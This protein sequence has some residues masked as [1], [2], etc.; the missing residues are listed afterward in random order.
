M[1]NFLASDVGIWCKMFWRKSRNIHPRDLTDGIFLNHVFCDIAK[2]DWNEIHQRL[3]SQNANTRFQNWKLLVKNLQEYYLDRLEHSIV[4]NPPSIFHIVYAPTSGAAVV[5]MEKAVLLLLLAAIKCEHREYFIRQIME[6]LNADVQRGIMQSITYFTEGRDG[7]LSLAGIHDLNPE[8]ELTLARAISNR[9][10]LYFRLAEEVILRICDRHPDWTPTKGRYSDSEGPNSSPKEKNA[11]KRSHSLASLLDLLGG[12]FKG[13]CPSSV[14]GGTDPG[15]GAHIRHHSGSTLATRSEDKQNDGKEAVAVT[16][17]AI[18][19]DEAQNLVD[20]MEGSSLDRFLAAVHMFEIGK[21]QKQIIDEIIELRSKSRKQGIQISEQTDELA[22]LHEQL[23]ES[24]RELSQLRDERARLADAAVC[25]RHWQDEAD[26]GQQAIAQL[27]QL[28]KEFEKLKQRLDAAQYYKIRCQELGEEI[29]VLTEECESLKLR[30]SK[31][32]EESSKLRLLEEKILE[33]SKR[34]LDLE[35]QHDK[36]LEEIQWMRNELT[37]LQLKTISSVRLQ[38]LSPQS[39]E[40]N[41]EIS[42]IND[43]LNLLLPD[44]STEAGIF[45]VDLPTPPPPPPAIEGGMQITQEIQIDFESYERRLNAVEKQL[46]QALRLSDQFQVRT[47]V[48]CVEETNAGF[49]NQEVSCEGNG[50]LTETLETFIC[51]LE[52]L[53]ADIETTCEVSRR[54][55][56]K[57]ESTQTPRVMQTSVQSTQTD[58]WPKQTT[59]ARDA[60]STANITRI[61]MFCTYAPLDS[62][63]E[64]VTDPVDWASRKELHAKSSH[65][66]TAN[67]RS[68]TVKQSTSDVAMQTTR[69]INHSISHSPSWRCSSENSSMQFNESSKAA[70]DVY[71][72]TRTPEDLSGADISS[73]IRMLRCQASEAKAQVTVLSAENKELLEQL[74]ELTT[75][76]DHSVAFLEEYEHRNTYLEKENRTLLLQMRSLLSQNQNVLTDALE[77]NE[78]HY[79]E[80]LALHDELAMLKRHKERLEEK[81]FEQYKMLPALK[82]GRNNLSLMQKARATF[83][84]RK[85]AYINGDILKDSFDEKITVSSGTKNYVRNMEPGSISVFDRDPEEQ[86]QN[87]FKRFLR[88]LNRSQVSNDMASEKGSKLTETNQPR[89][90]RAQSLSTSPLHG[91]YRSLPGKRERSIPELSRDIKSRDMQQNMERKITDIRP[92]SSDGSSSS[93]LDGSRVSSLM[94][95]DQSFRLPVTDRGEEDHKGARSDSTRVSGNLPAVIGRL[96][97][98]SSQ[99]D[100]IFFSRSQTCSRHIS[101][102]GHTDPLGH[103]PSIDIRPVKDVPVPNSRTTRYESS[104]LRVSKAPCVS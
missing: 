94:S 10:E 6:Q 20:L 17:E 71:D 70:T 51:H 50:K 19:E 99:V 76:F 88:G 15:V 8:L 37:D 1:E 63:I 24:Q 45:S 4:M 80:K 96:I 64:T 31:E 48:A 79:R 60:A 57:H 62:S 84:K 104:E 78:F 72:L 38:Q 26:A 91:G 54:R 9:E 27:K 47:P 28:E 65:P 81:I 29:T 98:P 18:A 85:G 46:L 52:K 86:D 11:A 49:S 59:G 101:P 21:G 93:T 41:D 95:F 12:S 5:E 43:Q 102:P 55:E 100:C 56:S 30:V 69:P 92:N 74:K 25:A 97:S 16:I 2:Y 44:R 36:D 3:S 73:V 83:Q 89:K 66:E 68:Q 13:T 90:L 87:D 35:W 67:Q 58:I 53:A 61:P 22:E 103:S 32:N 82:K 23:C 40:G 14:T 77:K 33:K 34:I 39:G 75:D 7:I 42:E